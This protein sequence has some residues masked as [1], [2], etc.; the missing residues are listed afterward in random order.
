MTEYARH[1][2]LFPPYLRPARPRA[3][4]SSSLY[5][6]GSSGGPLPLFGPEP[7]RVL[8]SVGAALTV[9]GAVFQFKT[10]AEPSKQESSRPEQT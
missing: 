1:V 4:L 9:P 8:L 5:G 3:I 2:P 7:L 6:M 10:A